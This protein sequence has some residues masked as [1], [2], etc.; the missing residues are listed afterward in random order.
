VVK[1]TYKKYKNMET[2]MK[3]K[4]FLTSVGLMSLIVAG[5]PSQGMATTINT[6]YLGGA[7]GYDSGSIAPG[8]GGGTV[9]VLIG[10]DLQNNATATSFNFA[11]AGGNFVTWCVDIAHWDSANSTYTVLPASDLANSG[12]LIKLANE[13]YSL[14]KDEYSSAAFQLAVWAI[15]FN[16]S[17]QITSTS[18]FT[19]TDSTP[20]ST[21]LA[22]ANGWLASLNSYSGPLGD[23]QLTYLSDD[24]YENTQDMVV[25]T[26]VPEPGTMAL[27][28]LGVLGLAV[29]GKR[30]RNTKD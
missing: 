24:P 13:D 9:N 16:S 18:A 12:T 26:P 23:Y 11:S 7:Y 28:G 1:S 3:I 6:T 29:Y 30:R 27:L 25:F 17:N 2:E 21:A 5:M 22:T 8:P 19:A 10:G 14:V 4:N 15:M 20:N